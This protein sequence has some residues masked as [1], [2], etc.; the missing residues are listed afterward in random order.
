ME[1][2]CQF[3]ETKKR[4]AL[5]SGF[6]LDQDQLNPK[7]KDFQ[8]FIV[9]K[10]LHHGKYALFADTGLGKTFM[11]LEWASHVSSIQKSLC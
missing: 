8:R 9:Q 4:K 1:D 10:A 2:Y 11:Q 7:L 5:R 6:K 3:I